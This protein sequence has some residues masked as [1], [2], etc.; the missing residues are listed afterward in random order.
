M[1]QTPPILLHH[2]RVNVAPRAVGTADQIHPVV[3]IQGINM[4]DIFVQA[5][6]EDAT[7]VVLYFN[8][9]NEYEL[10]KYLVKNLESRINKPVLAC[11][12]QSLKVLNK[13]DLE[14]FGLQ[15]IPMDESTIEK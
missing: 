1:L 12:N 7:A 10:C 3:V 15:K 5:I 6:P 11:L 9:E 2:I 8:D 13:E 14:S 4:T